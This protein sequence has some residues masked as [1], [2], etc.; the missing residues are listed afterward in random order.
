MSH[1][2]DA[3]VMCMCRSEKDAADMLRKQLWVCESMREQSE[4]GKEGSMDL[5]CDLQTATR[6]CIKS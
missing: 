2:R 6:F 5:N 3:G 4:E 1:I